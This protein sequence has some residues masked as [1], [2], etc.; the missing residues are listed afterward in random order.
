MGKGKE[1]CAGADRVHY[2]LS[3]S[4]PSLSQQQGSGD[5]EWGLQ[6]LH[7]KGVN[8][9]VPDQLE[10]EEMLEAFQP[11]RSQC[12]QSEEEFGKPGKMFHRTTEVRESE[13]III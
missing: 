12:W 11:N 6:H 7:E 9:R 13:V 1:G 5:L 4:V 3:W 2:I 10:E 8:R